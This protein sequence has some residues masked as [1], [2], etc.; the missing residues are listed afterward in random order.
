MQVPQ[1]RLDL[2]AHYPNLPPGP[3]LHYI[4]LPLDHDDPSLG[5]Y[6]G[7]YYL[8]RSFKP[9]GPVVFFLTDGQMEL[10]TTEIDHDWF[11]SFLGDLSYVLIGRRGHKPT[12]FPE[13]F[14][15]DETLNIQKA[16][17]LYGSWQHVKDI[18]AIRKDMQAKGLLPPSGK[19]MLFGAS[20]A[21]FLAQQFIDRYGHN[22][23][24][25]L[26]QV[27]G[28]PDLAREN[29]WNFSQDLNEFDPL[30]AAKLQEIFNQQQIDR[31][32]LCYLLFQQARVSPHPQ[33]QIQS[34]LNTQEDGSWWS[35]IYQS[36]KASGRLA[37]VEFMLSSPASAAVKVRMTE[38]IGPD[39]VKYQSGSDSINLMYEWSFDILKPFLAEAKEIKPMEL[40]NQRA[41][42]D[43][44]VLV[45][46]GAKDIV[47][48]VR[49]NRAL[50]NAYTNSRLMILDEGHRFQEVDGYARQLRQTFF[51][52]GL[53]SNP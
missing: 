25:V 17:K 9:K 41:L 32:S 20:G 52:E 40:D 42:Y 31:P 12:L 13:V 8:S 7:F 23:S 53:D 44:E 3:N 27:S 2:D 43:G 29:N 34:I 51:Q 38:L 16:V 19:I 36:W 48:S 21:G 1:T 37:L 18:E 22:V 11:D 45:I 6:R 39:V 46:A 4:N 47:F 35:K 50:A 28:A 33:N 15:P 5:K 30:S 14:N 26:I 10:V 24:R 49:T